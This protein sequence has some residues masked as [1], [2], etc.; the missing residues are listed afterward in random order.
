MKHIRVVA[1]AAGCGLVIS[2]VAA[3]SIAGAAPV[4]SSAP[5][6]FVSITPCRLLD[7]RPSSPVG[8]HSRPLGQN[9]TATVTAVGTA[10][11]CTI[12]SGTTGLVTNV[13][14]DNPTAASFLTLWPAG[15]PLPTSSNLNWLA[16]QAPTPNQ[17]TVGL[18]AAGAFNVRNNTGTV[19]V[20]IDVVGYYQP[21]SPPPTSGNWGVVDRD[22]LGSPVA[23][24]RSG[25]TFGPSGPPF[26]TG[27]LNL[28]VGSG[29]EKIAYGDDVD[30]SGMDFDALTRVGF[31]VFNVAENLSNGTFP[32]PSIAIEVNPQL[33]AFPT[34]LFSTLVY[35]PDTTAPGW[36]NFID[37]TTTGLWGGTGAAFA[38]TACDIN[39][40]RCTWAQLKAMLDD[41]GNPATIFSIQI[42]KGRDQEWHGAVDGLTINNTVYN[43]EENGVIAQ[44]AA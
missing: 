26:G 19:N 40:T 42:T 44:P 22:T 18:S 7:T 16:K 1:I 8:N 20:I 37:A 3:Y 15:A 14:I 35:F 2:G 13:T 33:T 25:P 34:D 17:V 10:G 41:G 9:E 5:S 38:G 21:V 32:M 29:T 39:G 4:P 27:S 31:Y 6:S 43:F 11:H 24:L 28:T 23:Q 36:S 12:P 30:F